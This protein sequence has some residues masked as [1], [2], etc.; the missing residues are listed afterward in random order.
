MWRGGR[1]GEG[2]LWGCWECSPAYP[3]STLRVLLSQPLTRGW[4]RSWGGGGWEARGPAGAEEKNRLNVLTAAP[5]FFPSPILLKDL[6][7]FGKGGLSRG[8]GLGSAGP[9]YSERQALTLFIEVF[10]FGEKKGVVRREWKFYR[11][12]VQ[13]KPA[14]KIQ[15]IWIL[16]RDGQQTEKKRIISH[17]SSWLLGREIV[18]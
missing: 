2:G 16:S 17:S 9:V 6:I 12:H 4:K 11:V 15:S 5:F 13:A 3:R 1:A 10:A 14:E 18:L 8:Q 7:S